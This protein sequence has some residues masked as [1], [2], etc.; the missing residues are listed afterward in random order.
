MPIVDSESVKAAKGDAV[1][2]VSI[3]G[4]D[5]SFSEAARQPAVRAL[6]D[7]VVRTIALS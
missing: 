4:G 5:H 7:W 2:S 6:V 1:A 3:D